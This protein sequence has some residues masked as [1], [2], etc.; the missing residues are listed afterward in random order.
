MW[1]SSWTGDG[2]LVDGPCPARGHCLHTIAFFGKF[3]LGFGN[4]CR[5]YERSCDKTFKEKPKKGSNVMPFLIALLVI[6]L[7][8]AFLFLS[9][10][11]IVP[12]Q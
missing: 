3:L 10:L 12:Q 7:I 5:T 11:F 2:W 4:G 1:V 8:I 6:A 9:T